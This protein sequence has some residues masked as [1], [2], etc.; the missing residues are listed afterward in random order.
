MRYPI[1]IL[2]ISIFILYQLGITMKIKVSKLREVLKKYNINEGFLDWLNSYLV[3]SRRKNLENKLNDL[4]T[5]LKNYLIDKFGS[6][7]KIPKGYLR[8][9]NFD[10]NGNYI[11]RIK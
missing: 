7:D 10:E 6:W 5:N 4:N 8:L 2:G 1:E 9:L 3:N 11:R